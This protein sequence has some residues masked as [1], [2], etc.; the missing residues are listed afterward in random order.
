MDKGGWVEE[1]M[2]WAKQNI[3]EQYTTHDIH[4]HCS[5]VYKGVTEEKDI[6]M[7]HFLI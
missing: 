3:I 4:W 7:H 5:V 2:V 1:V 6:L